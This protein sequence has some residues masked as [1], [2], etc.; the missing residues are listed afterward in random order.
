MARAARAAASER[1]ERGEIAVDDE[2]D[3]DGRLPAALTHPVVF[4]LVGAPH[5]AMP[6][7]YVRAAVQAGG[8]APLVPLTP[9]EQ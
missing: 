9:V 1:D 3:A 2:G 8:F 6:Q 5:D 4:A 7:T